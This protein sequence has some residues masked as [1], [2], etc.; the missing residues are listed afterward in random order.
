MLP[1]DSGLHHEKGHLLSRFTGMLVRNLHD[2]G[3]L[4]IPFLLTSVLHTAV[5]FVLSSFLSCRTQ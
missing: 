2:G 3:L 1:Q 5:F 4:E